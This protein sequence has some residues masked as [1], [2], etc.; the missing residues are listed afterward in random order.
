MYRWFNITVRLWICGS[1]VDQP[2]TLEAVRRI[3]SSHLFFIIR[4]NFN[5]Y[6]KK[7]LKLNFYLCIS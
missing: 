2:I 5:F 6:Q 3:A 4:N 1:Q 7:K